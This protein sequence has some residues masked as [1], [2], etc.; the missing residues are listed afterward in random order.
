MNGL[1]LSDVTLQVGERTLLAGLSVEVRPGEILT[2]MGPS[3]AG[4]SSLLGYIAGT[5][6]API[7]GSGHISI[8]GVRLDGLP[9]EERRLGLLLQRPLLFPHMTVLGN[10]VFAIPRRV[11]GRSARRSLAEAALT[12]VDLEGFGAR[13]PRTL[14]GGEQARVALARCLLAEPRALLLDEPFA[15]LDRGLRREIREHV[16]ARA[17]A[18]G[19]PTLLVSHDAGDAAAAGGRIVEPWSGRPAG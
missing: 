3:G 13:A 6:T 10:L 1:S 17:R 18:S 9:P 7:R 2:L 5:T 11:R 16:L 14:S 8:D 15:A 4:K 12:A 19:L